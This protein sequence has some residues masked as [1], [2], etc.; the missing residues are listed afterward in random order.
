MLVT[1]SD[2]PD[3]FDDKL[4]VDVCISAPSGVGSVQRVLSRQRQT[5]RA[6]VQ[7]ACAH[8]EQL[9]QAA[10]ETIVAPGQRPSI[11]HLDDSEGGCTICLNYDLGPR[12]Q[13]RPRVV[14]SLC[15]FVTVR[16]DGTTE[17]FGT[18]PAAPAAR[19]LPPMAGPRSRPPPA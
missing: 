2:F 19:P 18:A 17:S 12:N 3:G 14:R 11:A 4:I 7:Q 13:V 10:G 6:A 1:L 5:L 9:A 15:L 16:R 8:A